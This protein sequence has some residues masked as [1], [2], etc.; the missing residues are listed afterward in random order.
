ME[1]ADLLLQG[2]IDMHA[3]GYPQ[4]TLNMPPRVDNYEWAQ[5]AAN[6]GMAGFVIK[7]HIWPTANEAYLLGRI[8][9]DVKI[10]GSVTLNYTVGGI[11]PL[12][13]QIAAES[14]AKVIFMPTWC[15]KNDVGKGMHYADRM[16][17]YVTV[18][19]EAMEGKTGLTVFDDN[20]T[21]LPE[22]TEII[23][24]CKLY[25][26]VLAS[27][28]LSIAE[29]LALCKAACNAGVKFVLN[30]PLST[31]LIAASLDQMKEIAD[32][33]G[34]IENCF[35]GCMPMHERMNPRKI[36]EVIE[37]VGAQRCTMATDAIE[38]WNPPPPEVLRMYIA[39]MLALG[40]SD[41]AVYEMTHTNP[42]YLLGM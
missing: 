5:A 23:G 37:Y 11:S 15:S 41:E 20:G 28:H 1:K 40:V 10:F 12:A 13:V 36:V 6:A 19:D 42:A 18:I 35:I 25:G 39:T 33:G 9:N 7:S 17:P 27:G 16:R 4:F 26:L 8:V 34:Y 2:A 22:V 38:A 29:S 21:L 24:I 31:P 3:H 14:G 30:H 32:S